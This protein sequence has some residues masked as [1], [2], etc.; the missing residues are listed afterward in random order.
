MLGAL[1]STCSTS[2]TQHRNGH[3]NVRLRRDRWTLVLKHKASFETSA[4][5]EQAAHELRRQTRVD[6]DATALHMALAL[7]R[8]GQVAVV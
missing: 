4:R 3:G 1:V 5:Q 7:N 6:D 2:C 8:D